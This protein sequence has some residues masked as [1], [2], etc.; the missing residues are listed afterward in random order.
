METDYISAEPGLTQAPTGMGLL[1]FSRGRWYGTQ[2]AVVL[3][4][5]YAM[6]REIAHGAVRH[7]K[8]SHPDFFDAM[9]RTK[10]AEVFA[11]L[12]FEDALQRAALKLLR[13][14]DSRR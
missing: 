13:E 1:K 6:P 9:R 14:A 10:P 4:L 12:I 2:V 7:A 3:Q 11:D 5:K 8:T